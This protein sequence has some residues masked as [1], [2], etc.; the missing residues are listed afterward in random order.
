MAK[1]KQVTID[2]LAVMVARGFDDLEGR[3]SDLEGRMNLR[4]DHVDK[5]FAEADKKFTNI[6][7]QLRQVRSEIS[8]LRVELRTSITSISLRLASIEKMTKE[9]ISVLGDEIFNLKKR[10]EILEKNYLK[11]KSAE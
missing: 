6:D 5:K 4:F 3:F 1:K 2:D 8:S 7:Y 11:L 10:I 9:D